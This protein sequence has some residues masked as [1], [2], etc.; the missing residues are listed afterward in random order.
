MP[1]ENA[2]TPAPATAAGTTGTSRLAPSRISPMDSSR[3]NFRASSFLKNGYVVQVNSCSCSAVARSAS[4]FPSPEFRKKAPSGILSGSCPGC[5]VQV[6]MRPPRHP[7]PHRKRVPEMSHE[8]RALP[9]R[10]HGRRR[11]PWAFLC[12]A[13]LRDRRGSSLRNGHGLKLH[14]TSGPAEGKVHATRLPVDP[15]DADG[16]VEAGDRPALSPRV[17]SSRSAARPVSMAPKTRSRR[18]ADRRTL[19]GACLAA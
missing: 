7:F 5:G 6:H 19:C 14:L 8:E 15:R 1:S 10:R 12:T 9:S 3:T 2:D 11:W 4:R 18:R 16:A 17:S 13:R